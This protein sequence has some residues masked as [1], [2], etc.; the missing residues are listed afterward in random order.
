MAPCIARLIASGSSESSRKVFTT[1]VEL[2]SLAEL[3]VF[4]ILSHLQKSG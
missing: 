4:L 1:G 3:F 2:E